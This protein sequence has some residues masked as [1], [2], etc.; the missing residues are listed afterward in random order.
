[1]SLQ[2]IVVTKYRYRGW[3][4]NMYDY[5]PSSNLPI[6]DCTTLEA[7]QENYDAIWRSISEHS[8][9]VV[10]VIDDEALLAQY[11][12]QI[13][14]LHELLCQDKST[15]NSA[16]TMGGI[17]KRFG[18]GAHPYALEWR[19]LPI[20]RSLFATLY[21]TT[22]SDMTVS[23]DAV[24]ILG[25][26]AK[27]GPWS[28]NV[29][30]T[31]ADFFRRTGGKL[32]GHV[33]VNPIEGTPGSYIANV[34]KQHGKYFLQSSLTLLP[35][36]RGGASFVY[37]DMPMSEVY[38]PT[39]ESLYDVYNIKSGDY[40]TLGE[41]GYDMA[42]GKWKQVDNIPAG[43]LILFCGIH[44]N[45]LADKTASTNRRA[46]SYIC[47]LPRSLFGFSQSSWDALKKKKMDSLVNGKTTDHNPINYNFVEYGGNHYSNG[48]GRTRVIFG[49]H[50][51]QSRP[52]YSDD[53]YE[54]IL[55]AL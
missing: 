11:A 34:L 16:R 36:P 25:E 13:D 49:T 46:A 42:H 17:V 47:W 55:E 29:E 4:K 45:K 48:K 23:N 14:E 53:L 33:D 52:V 35:V 26:D 41:K 30:T 24:C 6:F 37:A 28:R 3:T 44:A 22:S 40:I 27:R 20:I 19:L 38:R 54:R 15:P 2:L 1:M 32:P 50:E 51:N 9:C 18:A 5:L 7:Q 39:T 21:D 10:R 31:K 43:C 12:N 8:C